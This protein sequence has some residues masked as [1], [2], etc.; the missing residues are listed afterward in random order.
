MLDLILILSIFFAVIFL[1]I[2]VV[3]VLNKSAEEYQK[4]YTSKAS[5]DF[6]NMFIY[7]SPNQ[8]FFLNIA[9]TAFIFII[10]FLLFSGW[11]FR[12]V[13]SMVGFWLPIQLVKYFKLKRIKKFNTQ[14][15][16][17][18]SQM[19]NAFKAG[20]S[21]P[22]AMENIAQETEAPIAL[23]FGFAIKEMKLGVPIEESLINMSKRVGSDDLDLVVV[24]TN[25]ARQ[26]GGNMSEMYE[27]ISATI[28]ERFRLE[29]KIASLVSQGKMQ[30]I[31]VGILP[32]AL[33]LVLAQMRPDLMEPMLES[34][35]GTIL[36]LAIIIMEVLGAFVIKK[37]ITI[38]V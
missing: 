17:A 3:E 15:V 34:W 20:L 30:G 38:D 19:A 6:E 22:Q 18:L 14:L 13:F 32:L 31:V 37:I 25:I 8:L 10:V 2:T 23:E 12:I 21:Y 16:D 29:G 26:M 1:V 33:G 27:T 9:F 4:K 36:I 11:T 5:A 7:I 35:F 28:R 24:S